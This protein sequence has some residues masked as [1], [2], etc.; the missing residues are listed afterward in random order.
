VLIADMTVER[1]RES[2]PASFLAAYRRVLGAIEQALKQPIRYAGEGDWGTF[3]L[4]VPLALGSASVA[5]IP[6]TN[7]TDVCVVVRAE[8]W[9]TFS[10]F[11]L[12]IEALCLHEWCLFSET[13]DQ[14][15]GVSIDRGHVYRLLTDRPDN[16]RPLTWE[17]NR[18]DLL[19]L[20]GRV[21]ECPWTGRRIVLGTA[22]DLD[23]LVPL[24]V[25]PMNDLWNLVPAD[26]WFNQHRKRDRLPSATALI[27]ATARLELAYAN[28]AG[29]PD[30]AHALSRDVQ[31]RFSAL[32]ADQAGSAPA[33]AGAVVAY[34]AELAQARNIARF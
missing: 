2:Y 10:E 24:V 29:Q 14:P 17:R 1:K 20:E 31:G 22:Y 30:L 6:G 8:L 11:S 25:Y 23:H 12:W 16:R 21:F 15:A 27:A 13:V 3:N 33:I 18:V 5:A 4:P 28:Y 34:L 26:Q 32:G 9:Q 19:L 7:P